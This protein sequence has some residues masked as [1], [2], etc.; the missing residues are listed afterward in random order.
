MAWNE[1]TSSDVQRVEKAIKNFSK[2][3]TI[4]AICMIV[5]ALAQVCLGIS[6]L[7]K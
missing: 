1:A 2:A 6:I 3:S 7:I 4:L 5:L